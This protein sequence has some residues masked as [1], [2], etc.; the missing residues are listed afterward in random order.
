MYKLRKRYRKNPSIISKEIG[1][2][3][4]LVPIRDD[5]GDL[6]GNIYILEGIGPYIWGL[7]DGKKLVQD[8]KAIIAEK[9]GKNAEEIEKDLVTF[10]QQL[11]EKGLIQTENKGGK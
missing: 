1:E 8:I 6:S 4:V 9:F 7:F 5:I 2:E 3:M 11:E 10:I